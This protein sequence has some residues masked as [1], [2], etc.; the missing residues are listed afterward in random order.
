VLR[1]LLDEVMRV[2]REPDDGI[3]EARIGPRPYVHSKLMCWAALDR[4]IKI[5][6]H[7]SF[8]GE[9]ERWSAERAAT[10]DDILARGYNEKR[11]SSPSTTKPRRSMRSCCSS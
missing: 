5:A 7:Y 6:G 2:W 11:G 1:P 3:W 8:P 10:R 9:L 4:A